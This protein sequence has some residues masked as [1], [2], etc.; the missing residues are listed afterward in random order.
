MRKRATQGVSPARIRVR[1]RNPLI[2]MVF[3]IVGFSIVTSK[4]STQVSIRG[5]SRR[6]SD[7]SLCLIERGRA[8][9]NDCD[10][11]INRRYRKPGW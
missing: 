4:Y 5:A 7:A 3:R 10:L 9:G 1:C 8:R 2:G 6:M 11:L